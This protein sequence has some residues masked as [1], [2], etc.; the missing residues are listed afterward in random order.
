MLCLH[1][2]AAA[3]AADED[4]TRILSNVEI[5]WGRSLNSCDAR[6]AS[7]AALELS[8]CGSYEPCPQHESEPSIL[9]LIMLHDLVLLGYLRLMMSALCLILLLLTF[10]SGAPSCFSSRCCSRL[11]VPNCPNAQDSASK[12]DGCVTHSG[13]LQVKQGWAPSWCPARLHQRIA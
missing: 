8:N 2:Q 7:M 13:C 11:I 5:T 1:S 9:T 12:L 10:C 4:D 3:S 6:T